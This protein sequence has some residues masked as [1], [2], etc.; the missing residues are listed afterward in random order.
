MIMWQKFLISYTCSW[1]FL[2]TISISVNNIEIINNSTILR[3]LIQFI[4]IIAVFWFL[5]KQIPEINIKSVSRRKSALMIIGFEVGYIVLRGMIPD[6][7]L[8]H[9]QIIGL[10]LRYLYYLIIFSILIKNIKGDESKE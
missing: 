2:I 10:V 5:Y 6:E 9:T 1:L 7:V 3:F 4:S 8:P